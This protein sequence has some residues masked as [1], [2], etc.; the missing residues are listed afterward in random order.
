MCSL[1][2]SEATK[3]TPQASLHYIAI[4]CISVAHSLAMLGN[5][6]RLPRVRHASC[7]GMRGQYM[8]TAKHISFCDP[9]PH[10][11]LV[12]VSRREESYVHSVTST[13]PGRMRAVSGAAAWTDW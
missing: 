9:S 12:L 5:S 6:V 4:S 10:L 7:W 2:A 3:P 13:S 8:M 11:M 1:L